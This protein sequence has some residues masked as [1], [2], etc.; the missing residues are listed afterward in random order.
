VHN[1]IVWQCRRTADI[2]HT[3]KKDPAT[4][5]LYPRSTGLVIDA[6]F[7]GTKIAWILDNVPGARERADKGDIAFG[8]VD[9][10]LIWR[11]TSG[12]T[13]VTD[14]SNAS[15]TMVFN[16][17]TLAWDDKLLAPLRIPRAIL[18]EVRSSSEIYGY[19]MGVPGLPDGIP[20][21]GVAG[22]QQAALFGQACY[23]IGQGKCTYGTGA[24]LLL[25]TGRKPI[26]STTG[27]LTTVAWKI[28]DEVTYALEGSVFIAGAAVQW[29]RDG[30]HLICKSPEIEDQA[31][32]VADN[33]GVVFVPA[34]VGLGCPHWEP[35]AR[36]AI[37]GITRGTTTAH[38][39]RATLEGIAHEVTDIIA[40][41]ERDLERPISVLKV[42]GGAAVNNI[43]MQFQADMLRIQVE[44]PMVVETTGLGAAC[45]AGLAVGVWP[46]LDT[47]SATWKL[48][49]VF[50]PEMPKDE[51]IRHRGMWAAGLRAVRAFSHG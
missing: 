26:G 24:F 15:R 14:V 30:L 44:R 46:D 19:T 41:M 43:L 48:D 34:L 5:D 50:G 2:C 38:L 21:A 42:D 3:L 9:T 6:Y 37:L 23:E 33:G 39:C 29:L 35:E 17:H 25:N 22:D 10:Y 18:P 1:A 20:I 47:I 12:K 13:H 28:G 32:V 40:G 36:G 11:L 31:A 27:L 45:L 4:K 7:S 49:R 8:T 16:I 51:R